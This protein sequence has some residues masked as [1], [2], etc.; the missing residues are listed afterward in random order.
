MA[1]YMKFGSI[2]G[3]ATQQGYEG[4]I[5]ISSFSW[6][7]H[8]NFAQDQVGRS[9]NREASQAQMGRCIVTK[10]VDH[11]SGEILK[12]A[13]TAFKGEPVEIVFL[14]TGNPGEAY[15]TFKLT[16]ALVSKLAVNGD[17]QD[18]PGETIEIDFTELEIVCK[19]LDESNVAEDTMHITYNAATGI[20]G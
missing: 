15:L 16:D 4:Y 2:Q 19:T 12:A 10:D 14:R 7:L 5:N 3:D 13:A 17:G 11:S 1:I 6:G 8:R 18:R 9:F 20:G